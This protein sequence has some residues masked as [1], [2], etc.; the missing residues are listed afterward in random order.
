LNHS[1]ILFLLPKFISFFIQ[2]YFPNDLLFIDN[3]AKGFI[4]HVNNW[5]GIASMTFLIL[6]YIS[7][8]GNRNHTTTWL[9]TKQAKA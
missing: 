2:L 3:T 1:A 4:Y 5:I 8:S 6:S 7:R 9:T